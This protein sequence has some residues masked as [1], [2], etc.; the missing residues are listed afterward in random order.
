[1]GVIPTEIRFRL[2][3]FE[4]VDAILEVETAS[5]TVP[6]SRQ[7][8]CGELDDNAYAR[9]ILAEL[10][11][12]VIGYAGVWIIFDEGHVTNI[13]IHPDYRGYHYGE[14]IVR[15]L[16]ELVRNCGAVKMTLEVR[17][18]NLIAQ[19]LYKK[20]G[21]KAQGRRKGYYSDNKEDAIIMWKDEL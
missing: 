16:I 11:G 10:D 17:A 8:F 19:S 1:M 4:D 5:F 18:S 9:Y 2:A 13:A 20:L 6:W 21:F 7:A 12:K 14:Q 15:H 3:T